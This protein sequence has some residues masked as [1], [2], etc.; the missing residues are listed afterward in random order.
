MGAARG[1]ASGRASGWAF[2]DVNR[3]DPVEL[4][5]ASNLQKS[6][7]SHVAESSCEKYTR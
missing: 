7:L 5:L 2:L 4:A 3:E 6:A 1:T